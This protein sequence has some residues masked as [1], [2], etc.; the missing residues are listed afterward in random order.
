MKQARH[1]NIITTACFCSYVETNG[2]EKLISQKRMVPMRVWE[3]YRANRYQ[4]P[5]TQEE[6]ILLSHS[7]VVATVIVGDHL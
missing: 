5:A 7:T 1:I 3:E 6:Y 2:K 4:N